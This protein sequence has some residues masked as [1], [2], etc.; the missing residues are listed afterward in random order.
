MSRRYSKASMV[1]YHLIICLCGI[2]MI[3]PL[4]WM[5]M[6]S[7]KES[8]TVYI[9]ANSL[10]PQKFV[11][12]NYVNGWK[13]FGG[14]SFSN[15]FQNSFFI[16][17]IGTIGAVVSSSFVAYGFARF[18]NFPGRKILFSCMLVAM[19]MP[20]QVIMVPQFIWFKKLNMIGG[21]L[22]LILPKFFGEGFFIFLLLQFMQGIPR[23]I[24][25]AARIDGCS[26]LKI[27]LRII[28]PL[29][30]PALITCTIFSFMWKWE[31]YL[32]PLLYIN[33]TKKYTVSI[34]LKLF[35][36]PASTSDYGATFAMAT[37]SVIPTLLIFVCLQKY[38]V[39]GIS[40][41]GLK[42]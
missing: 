19:M 13:G 26:Y 1:T 29:I 27:F 21:Y 28:I 6:S 25:E 20:F 23:E 17:I 14:V 30:V 42:G 34:A 7:F 9:T 39:E 38:L 24:D 35:C 36:D 11:L 37:L 5:I 40:T 32:A 4:V 10:I 31:D 22:P 33:G 16:A 41:T 8:K 3:Y 12:E 15:F 2:I 18:H